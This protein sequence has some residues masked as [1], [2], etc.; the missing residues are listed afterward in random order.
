MKDGSSLID[1][2]SGDEKLQIDINNLTINNSAGR[3]SL[4]LS[5]LTVINQY[6]S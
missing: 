3:I 2:L 4:K 6:S 1:V 5:A